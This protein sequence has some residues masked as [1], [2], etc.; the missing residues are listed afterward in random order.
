MDPNSNPET[1]RVI[2]EETI[3][4]LSSVKDTLMTINSRSGKNGVFPQFDGT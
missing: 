2:K 1:Q 4:N 3:N